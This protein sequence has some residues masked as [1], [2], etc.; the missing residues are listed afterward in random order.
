MTGINLDSIYPYYSNISSKLEEIYTKISDK[1]YDITELFTE[2]EKKNYTEYYNK[3]L[4]AIII[5][6]YYLFDKY[7]NKELGS[8][9]KKLSNIRDLYDLD[10]ILNLKNNSIINIPAPGHATIL[11]KYEINGRKYIYYSNSGIGIDNNIRLSNDENNYVA[12]KIFEVKTDELFNI[13]PSYIESIIEKISIIGINPFSNDESPNGFDRFYTEINSIIYLKIH[14]NLNKS[15]KDNLEKIIIPQDFFRKIIDIIIKITLP[16]KKSEAIINLCYSLLYYFSYK[17]NDNFKECLLIDLIIEEN[18]KN[19]LKLSNRIFI[20]NSL[21]SSESIKIMEKNQDQ[22]KHKNVISQNI[23]LYSIYNT[24]SQYNSYFIYEIGLNNIIN[25]LG[26]DTSINNN[27]III[28]F[29]NFIDKIN[30]KLDLLSNQITSIKFKIDQLKIH[31]YDNLIVNPIQKSGSCTFYS[32][33]YLKN[34][35]LIESFNNIK[36]LDE[37]NVKINETIDLYIN[38]ILEFHFKMIHLYGI[39]QDIKLI[40]K[41]YTIDDYCNYNFINEICDS[42]FLKNEFTYI[43]NKNTFILNNKNKQRIDYLLDINLDGKYSFDNYSVNSLDYSFYIDLVNFLKEKINTIRVKKDYNVIQLKEDFDIN[44]EKIYNIIPDKLKNSVFYEKWD[45]LKNL[46]YVYLLILIYTYNN[47]LIITNE[48]FHINILYIHQYKL[49]P[50]ENINNPILLEFDNSY[51]NRYINYDILFLLLDNVEKENI[52]Y[53]INKNKTFSKLD[54]LINS[55]FKTKY[56]LFNF[57]FS[58]INNSTFIRFFIDINNFDNLIY[59]NKNNIYLSKIYDNKYFGNNYDVTLDNLYKFFCINN[60]I[61]H[62]KTISENVKN[63]YKKKITSNILYFKK[64]LLN[65][66]DNDYYSLL[67]TN[68]T[69]IEDILL[70]ISNYNEAFYRD[71]YLNCFGISYLFKILAGCRLNSKNKTILNSTNLDLNTLIKIVKNFANEEN[72]EWENGNI[73]NN[74]LSNSISINFNWIGKINIITDNYLFFKYE[75]INYYKINIYKHDYADPLYKIL[76]RFGISNLDGSYLILNMIDKINNNEEYINMKKKNPEKYEVF[77]LHNYTMVRHLLNSKIMILTSINNTIL[78]SKC[79]ILNINENKVDIDNIYIIDENNNKSRLLFNLTVEKYPFF[80]FIPKDSLYLYYENTNILELLVNSNFKNKQ[81]DIQY[82][83]IFFEDNSINIIKNNN[84]NKKL[85]NILLKFKIGNSSIFPVNNF[86]IDDYKYSFSYYS[87]K[88]INLNDSNYKWNTFYK[89][90]DENN[91]L[92]IK[93]LNLEIIKIIDLCNCKISYELEN[94]EI[95]DILKIY[96]KKNKDTKN[97]ENANVEKYINDFIATHNFC[98]I[99]DCVQLNFNKNLVNKTFK[100]NINEILKSIDY[101]NYYINNINDFIVDNFEKWLLIMEN[102]A[103]IEIINLLSKDEISCWNIQLN[104][105]TLK[106]IQLFNIKILEDNYYY[107][108][109]I[110]FLLQSQYFYR[111][112]QLNKYHE[113][114][115]DLIENNSDLK[116]H[117]FM[118]GQGKTSVFTPLLSLCIKYLRNQTPTVITA[119]H[120][121]KDTRNYIKLSEF[122]LNINVNIFSDYEAKLRWLKNYYPEKDSDI[123]DLKNEC[124]II[125]EFDSHHNYLQSMFNYVRNTNN[126]FDQNIFDYIFNYTY[127][128]IQNQNIESIKDFTEINMKYFYLNENLDMCYNISITMKYNEN[129]GFAF[130]YTEEDIFEKI[131]IPFLRKDTPVFNSNFSSILLRLI[132]TFK[133]YI[134]QFNSFIQDFDYKNIYKNTQ[135]YNDLYGIDEDLNEFINNNDFD[136]PYSIENIK[137]LFET[138]IYSKNDIIINNNILKQYLYIVNKKKIEFT[139]EQLNMSFIDIIYNNHEQWQVGYTGT[140][141]LKLNDYQEDEKFVF[142]EIKKIYD[143]KM[144]ILLA[145]YGFGNS[146]AENKKKVYKIIED[147]KNINNEVKITNNIN[148]IIEVIKDNP[149]G[150]IDLY[151]IFVNYSNEIISEKICDYFQKNNID[152]NIIYIDKNNDVYEINSISKEISKFKGVRENNFYYYDQTHTV[153]TDIK[154]PQTGHIAIIISEKNRISEFA[155]AIFRFRKLNRG[156]Y[157]SVILNEEN[158]TN[159]IYT[160]DNI[161]DILKNNE[162]IFVENQ[163]DGLKYQLFKTMIRKLQVVEEQCIINEKE[164]CTKAFGECNLI[165]YYMQKD[166]NMNINYLLDI[167]KNNIIKKDLYNTNIKFNNRNI[168]NFIKSLF[169][170]FKNIGNK[171]IEKLSQLVI[172]IAN[173]KVIEINNEEDEE[174]EENQEED[175]DKEN[176]KESLNELYLMYK[177]NF[178][179]CFIKNI[180]VIK[181]LNCKKCI[182][183]NCIR[184][185]DEGS[186]IKINGKYIY[187]SYN[188]L[189]NID[190][191][192]NIFNLENYHHYN[193]KII[194]DPTFIFVVLS[195]DKILIETSIVAMNYYIHKLPIYS[196]NGKI[197]NPCMLDKNNNIIILDIDVNFIKLLGINY[198]LKHEQRSITPNI[199]NT[200]EKLTNIGKLLLI[201]HL[202]NY[203]KY[204]DNYIKIEHVENIKKSCYDIPKQFEID[205]KNIIKNIDKWL[206]IIYNI[207]KKKFN[208]TMNH[209][210]ITNNNNLNINFNKIFFP[211]NIPIK[212]Y[213]IYL[214]EYGYDESKMGD[215]I[216]FLSQYIPDRNIEELEVLYNF[217]N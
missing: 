203:E 166:Q 160:I 211:I 141:Y 183:E 87:N 79:I 30:N 13:I 70:I 216:I 188:F 52:F 95:K 18:N 126:L 189:V 178:D 106:S 71:D 91:I 37:S 35:M 101:T 28:K 168:K 213:N 196:Y 19:Y 123:L 199:E 115:N 44:F 40:S 57:S 161:Y 142:K 167:I 55:F 172:G 163:N 45:L 170:Y 64:L 48:N 34:F 68:I 112:S 156:T 41:I 176:V 175:Q 15:I 51:Y 217:N 107:K 120:L 46:Y 153:G 105:D 90:T 85:K 36:N 143:E 181:H 26:T 201:K 212:D 121:V 133:T 33:Y 173:E 9:Y 162:D 139:T 109:E 89:I 1:N 58:E 77:K 182:Y 67:P 104:L 98:K 149:R 63:L 114:R 38:N 185:F 16:I 151:G 144:E 8:S 65:I 202:I 32:Y 147:S 132:L 88:Y 61:E 96:F 118:M 195:S 21:E 206:F 3:K 103:L 6:I 200:I 155:Q 102:N 62:D 177:E 81:N 158:K 145:L 137:N 23:N 100:D 138:K 7:I 146:N 204:R 75:D 54:E 53:I 39:S 74:Y 72:K 187:I 125:D 122:L 108:F 92:N 193:N 22:D 190:T 186:N 29:K 49:S 116:V 17:F 215:D 171:N 80:L 197:I 180:N 11:Y 86:N 82:D 69:Y 131:C 191:V 97:L 111:E 210:I 194:Y 184:L 214:N 76:G 4:N 117:Q 66:K 14:E 24:I 154:Q 128:K 20:N 99:K 50:D 208:K 205:I 56:E 135:L 78:P 94:S 209:N 192:Y 59:N 25:K 27:L 136:S 60:F 198:N 150:F 119:S 42:T 12:P 73:I 129:Y 83:N 207:K 164:I 174:E 31:Y 2:L 157:L 110:L 127:A 148:K 84:K 140:A 130:L 165:P 124:N 134:I 159:N 169:D 152:K 179:T 10:N 43:Y 47:D 113:I 93:K 5:P